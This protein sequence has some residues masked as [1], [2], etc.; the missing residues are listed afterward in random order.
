MNFYI[1]EEISLMKRI[2][3]SI[4]LS[5]QCFYSFSQILN[6]SLENN[7]YVSYEKY[8]YQSDSIFHSSIRPYF[9]PE[10]R[11]VFDYDSIK[12]SYE[13]TRFR[14]NRFLNLLFNR[15][16][17]SLQKIEYGFTLDPLFDF[18]YGYDFFNTE[19]TWTNTRGFIAEGYLGKTFSFST[20][21]YENQSRTPLWIQDY[22]TRRK[23]MPGQ[24]IVRPFG[25]DAVDYAN[26][27]GY[28][29][30]TPGKFFNF[31]LGHGK[32]FWGDGYRSLIL[33]D[34]SLSHPYFMITTTFWKI[35]YVN[36]YSQY[37]HPD[38]VYYP[39]KGLSENARKYSSMQYLSFVPGNNRW[40]ISLFE[41]VIWSPSDSSARG[42]DFN[43]LNPVIFLKALESDIGAS[44]ANSLVGMNLRY[45][46]LP[47]TSL[48]GQIVF[49]D[50]RIK[51]LFSGDGWA[52]NKVALQAGFKSF[53]LFGVNNLYFQGEYNFIRP[54][55][56]SHFIQVQ[57]YSNAREPLA[58]PSG[59]NIKEAVVTG[60]YNYKR[61]Y[62][63]AKYVLSGFGADTTGSDYGKDIFISYSSRGSEY[64]NK[65]GQGLYT[66][67][68]QL[69]ISV[70]FL[71]DPATNMNI[72]A[73]VTLR[74]EL[75]SQINNQYNL[76]S[77][78]FR[79]SLRNLY[80]DFY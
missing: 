5:I 7:Q 52:G 68:N 39:H 26:A 11:K 58:H 30:W 10:L 55:T 33:S 45:S 67:L 80:Y 22:Y 6:S 40:N 24:G 71:V 12:K 37:S 75:N 66:T 15:N 3:I 31:Q 73:S 46:V 61:L 13:I 53:D 4:F 38:I 79:T 76:F 62:F 48:Y 1:F 32:Q 70:S 2:I 63:N 44:S 54:Y 8:I 43:Y 25:T 57:N 23:V 51:D 56:Y 72:F 42:I 16:L 60:K 74:K 41:A 21:F 78:G 14:K 77:F 65:T 9:I 20:T 59:A 35:R 69:D 19:S 34:F 17:F 64:G 47:K 36:L 28:I 27:S 29:S 50:K 18:N 49:D